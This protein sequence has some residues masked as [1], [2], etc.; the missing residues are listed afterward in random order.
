MLMSISPYAPDD[1][2]YKLFL[3]SMLATVNL[4]H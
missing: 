3:E 2:P 4:I 1:V